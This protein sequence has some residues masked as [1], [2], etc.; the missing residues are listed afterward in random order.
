MRAVSE[1]FFE[2]ELPRLLYVHTTYLVV[3]AQRLSSPVAISSEEV[4][5]VAGSSEEG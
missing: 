3:L 2:Y 5:V 1:P 4:D